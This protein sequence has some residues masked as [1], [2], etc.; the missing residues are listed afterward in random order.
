MFSMKVSRVQM[1]FAK[2]VLTLVWADALLRA[3]T[4]ETSDDPGVLGASTTAFE[5]ALHDEP[6]SCD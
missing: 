6:L 1:L 3:W 4:L 5:G 2:C